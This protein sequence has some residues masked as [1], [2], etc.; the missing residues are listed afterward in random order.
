M[1]IP[2]AAIRLIGVLLLAACGES[3]TTPSDVMST[4]DL[5]ADQVVYGLHHIMTKDGVRSAVLDSDT[6]YLRDQGDTFE[7]SGVRLSFFDENGVSTGDLTARSG[8][9]NRTT[10]LFVARDDVV[11]VTQTPTGT[12]R[13]ESQNLNYETSSNRLWSS[14]PFVMTEG[15]RVTRGSSFESDG[16]FESWSANDVQTTGGLPTEGTGVSF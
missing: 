5:A 8:T 15:S 13:I 1:R 10:G 4:A 12:R 7:L 9:Y 3:S 14:V 6:A 2:R 16:K 11:L